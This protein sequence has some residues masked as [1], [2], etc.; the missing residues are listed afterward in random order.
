M[1]AKPVTV[2]FVKLVNPVIP[3]MVPGDNTPLNI[4]A[5][6]V[7]VTDKF[8]NPFMLVRFAEGALNNPAVTV[9]LTLT[10]AALILFATVRF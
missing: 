1:L 4:P 6:T 8:C 9:P 7:P 10:L 3:A 2:I 5:S